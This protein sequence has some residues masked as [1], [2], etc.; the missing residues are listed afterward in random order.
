MKL[1]QCA[2]VG[3]PRILSAGEPF[4]AGPSRASRAIVLASTTSVENSGLLD[5]ILPEFTKQTGITVHVLA[6][7]TGQALAT[8][9][10]GDADLVLVHD[11]E[12]E[13]QFIA[14]G[15]RRRAPADRLERFHR[16]RASRRSG[17]YRRRP[18]CGFGV[19]GDRR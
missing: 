7:G 19:Q 9:A 17:A 1:R 6:Q 5:H 15:A 14:E 16:G 3:S 2:T 18:R 4:A 10:R 13:Q 8:A 11:P 12:A